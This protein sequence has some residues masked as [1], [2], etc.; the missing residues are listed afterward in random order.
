LQFPL[1]ALEAEF[2]IRNVVILLA[3]KKKKLKSH[4][5]SEKWNL[6]FK[7][8]FGKKSPIQWNEEIILY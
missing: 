5:S 4:H 3:F 6:E 2:G 8:Q 1:K 7:Y